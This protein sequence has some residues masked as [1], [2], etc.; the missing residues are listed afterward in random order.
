[1]KNE[2]DL[3]KEQKQ[4]L[5]NNKKNL[6]VSA[7][8]GSG[9]TFV[10]I[11]YLIKLLC[12]K[13]IPVSRMLVLTFTKAAAGEMKTRLSKAILEE[14]KTDFLIEQL[15]DISI[16]DIS[17]IDSFCEKLLRRN[18]NKLEL[19]NNFVILDEKASKSLKYS[20][21]C[22]IFDKLANENNV[23][24][25]ELY[26]AFKKD[27][28]QLFN[29]VV[30]MESFFDSSHNSNDLL[31]SFIN[32]E[33]KYLEKAVDYV[34]DIIQTRI[35]DIEKFLNNTDVS[36]LS[37]PYF[38]LKINLEK[39]TSIK[40]QGDFFDYFKEI[41]DY[42]LMDTPR[43]KVND[44][45]AKD[46]LVLA[47]NKIKD[48]KKIAETYDFVN[49]EIKQKIQNNNISK[50]LL[51]LYKEYINEYQRLKNLKVAVDFADLESLA[52]KLLQDEEIKKDL[53]QRYDYIFIDEYQDTNTLQESIIKPIAEGG[54]FIAVG[55]P[56]QGIYG[57][58]NASME[59]MKNDIKDF[60]ESE[61]GEALFLTGN[62]RSDD[63]IL[64]F[65]NK[66]FEVIM[67]EESVGINYLKTSRLIGK[68]SFLDDE[69]PSV[70]VDIVDFP[71]SEEDA[72]SGVYS[73][74]DDR[75]SFL[76]KCENE[77]E[78]ICLR[79][80]QFLG[81]DIYDAKLKKMRKVQQ[82][83][84][85]IL[86]R[87]RSQIMKECVRSMQE[88]GFNVV[89]DIRQSLLE[90]GQVQVILSLIKLA[91]NFD[92]DI[93]LVS[94]MN[95]WFGGFSLDELSD[96]RIVNQKSK[97]YEIID[98]LSENNDKIALFV[99][100]INNFAFNCE[101]LGVVRAL[102]KL[103][104]DTD[105]NLYLNSL[106]SANMKKSHINELFKLIKSNDLE[107]NLQGIINYLNS[108]KTEGSVV[109]SA[110]NAIT[111][112]TIHATKGLEYPIVILAGCGEALGKTDRNPY[113]LSSK[114]GLG[115]Y[116]YDF[117]ENIKK[118]T[119]SFLANKLYK[120]KKEFIDE[121]MI[122]YVALTRAQNHLILIGSGHDKRGNQER[123]IVVSDD[124]FDCKTYFDMVFSGFGENF[125]SQVL[126]QS[127]SV[128]AGEWEFN[129]LEEVERATEIIREKVLFNQNDL[130]DNVE[131]YKEYMDFHY[132]DLQNCFYEY[133]NSVSHLLDDKTVLDIEKMS[134]TEEAEEKLNISR[135][136][137]ILRGNAYHEVLELLD[138]DKIE[139][140]E[141][142]Q[143]ECLSIKDKMT[144][145]YF[146][147]LDLDI[148][149]KNIQLIKSVLPEE[150]QL[151]KEKQFIMLSSLKECGIAD[152]ENEIIVQGVCDLFILGKQNILIDYKFTSQ[153]NDEKI[154]EKYKTQ[155]ELYTMAI[156]KA[157]NIKLDARYLL[158]LK[159]AHLIKL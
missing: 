126:S 88:K 116:V 120:K 105:Y 92:D 148:I 18:I 100:K 16:S 34:K 13:H 50:A 112:T 99:K 58:R 127:T 73:V 97:F 71:K 119:P 140:K 129:F 147:Y 143:K 94:A 103:F 145:G 38:N 52:H 107:F 56:K 72:P 37:E 8:A 68:Q 2:E 30:N 23:L 36:S 151:Y 29:A 11:E 123:T 121:I 142:L 79:V 59:I 69:K 152:S 1:M 41:N 81:Q 35:R 14:E 15:D 66:I 95:S 47:K 44:Q 6:I 135:Q 136:D 62:F 122:F 153:N 45:S 138:F 12:K 39:F 114:F 77:V 93:S 43:N 22:H 118:E 82:N 19:D 139:T 111:I 67:T 61:D 17:T 32:D 54:F 157:F 124:V 42:K 75:V 109:E 159:N 86:F 102:Q 101:T 27:R 134:L 110:S 25:D 51:I 26:F 85:A 10:V 76:R 132:P 158:S 65:V 20:S 24:F 125:L 49:D 113:N 74:K 108:V 7:S 144:E 31:N 48:I 117:D 115:T 57:F 156:E 91:L 141:D 137:A 146:E 149:F 28:E 155:I 90:D 5:N 130:L 53:Q 89:A 33:N 78:D 64:Q 154:K 55:D 70:I 40:Y 84:I 133:K 46:R 87:E 80:E 63:R 150:R 3:T 98:S 9:K 4:I 131:Y 96:L 128:R 60:A 83:D 104:I 21:F 106:P